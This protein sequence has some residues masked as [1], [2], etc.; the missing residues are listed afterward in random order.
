MMYKFKVKGCKNYFIIESNNQEQATKEF[1][2]EA[3]SSEQFQKLLSEV[4]VD[5]KSQWQ[6]FLELI[7]TIIQDVL[8][9]NFKRNAIAQ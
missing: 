3:M 7:Q 2:A 1:I 6:R 4:K 8:G 9:S 5:G